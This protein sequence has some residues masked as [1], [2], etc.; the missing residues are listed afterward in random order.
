M[1]GQANGITL[2]ILAVLFTVGAIERLVNPPHAS[3]TAM[4]IVAVVGVVVNVIATNLAMR[5]DRTRLS[6]RGAVSH[7]VNDAWAFAATAVAGVVIILTNWTRADAVASLGIAVLMAHTGIGL[8][9]AAGRI[10]L[11]AAPEGLDPD[12]L[13]AELADVDGVAQV[14][15]LHV[16]QLGPGEDAISAHVFVRPHHDCHQV[17]ATL[18]TVLTE[19]HGLRHATLQV[20]HATMDSSGDVMTEHCGE[21]HGIVHRSSKLPIDSDVTVH[22]HN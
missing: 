21:P 6:V 3:G 20:D 8:V 17:A 4:T 2:L 14:H 1:A 15:D 5:A 9:R 13:G 12:E 18:R 11:E 19:K 16:W 10:F 7:L 22:T